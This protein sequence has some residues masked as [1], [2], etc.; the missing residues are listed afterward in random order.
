[1]KLVD[2]KSVLL[3][4]GIGVI[5]ASIL[6][7]IFFMGYQPQLTDSEIIEKAKKLGMVDGLEHVGDITRNKDGTLTVT[8]HEG[9]GSG[10]V[11]EKLLD[12]GLI[13]SSIEF[14]LLI[15]NQNLETSIQPGDY[16][17]GFN[18]DIQVIIDRITGK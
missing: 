7:Y 11:A 15:K 12:A 6:G 17:I 14:Q 13:K 3:G 18:E 4:I 1:M 16:V 2:G 5:L 10:K 9:E 8:L